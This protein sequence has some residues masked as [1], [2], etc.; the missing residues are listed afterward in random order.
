MKALREAGRTVRADNR[1]S[2]EGPARGRPGALR[3]HCGGLAGRTGARGPRE[4]A[5]RGGNWATDAVMKGRRE[6]GRTDADARRK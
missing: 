4:R 1:C 3:W 5:V 6:A 2:H